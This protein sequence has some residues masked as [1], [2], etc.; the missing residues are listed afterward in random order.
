MLFFGF[1]KMKTTMDGKDLEETFQLLEEENKV[2]GQS[3]CFVSF[4]NF[5]RL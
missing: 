2:F 5:L 4:F 1:S 3:G